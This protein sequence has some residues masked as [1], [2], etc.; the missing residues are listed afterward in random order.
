M[1]FNISGLRKEA[2]TRVQA[3]VETPRSGKLKCMGFKKWPKCQEPESALRG[4]TQGWTSVLCR[5][6]ER[7]LILGMHLHCPKVVVL[8]RVATGNA[9]LEVVL[10]GNDISLKDPVQ[11]NGMAAQADDLVAHLQKGPQEL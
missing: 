8:P 11:R 1:K 4:M 6:P 7:R 9:A 5:M 3:P 2:K 10:A